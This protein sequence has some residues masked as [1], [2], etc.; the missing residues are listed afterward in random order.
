MCFID[1]QPFFV[2]NALLSNLSA[3][4]DLS[5]AFSETRCRNKNNLCVL[6]P[7]ATMRYFTGYK[8]HASSFP[9]PEHCYQQEDWSIT[10]QYH[11]KTKEIEIQ[12]KKCLNILMTLQEKLGKGI[13]RTSFVVLY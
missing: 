7:T 6:S 2:Q 5:V 10:C 12:L 8:E 9:F 1:I 4:V 11:A 13:V 3:Q